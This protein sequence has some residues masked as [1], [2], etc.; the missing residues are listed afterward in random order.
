MTLEE[1]MVI[2]LSGRTHAI[3]TREG[4]SLLWD[5]EKGLY[6][7]YEPTG[8]KPQT[9]FKDPTVAVNY[10]LKATESERISRTDEE[11]DPGLPGPL[12]TNE[13]LYSLPSSGNLRTG[14]YR[15][16]RF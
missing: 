1:A 14:C 15:R 7:V 2:V 8:K 3:H 11:I 10:F 6:E 5:N 16:R 13:E 9:Y 12:D 4:I